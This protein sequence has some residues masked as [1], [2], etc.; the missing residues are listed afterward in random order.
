MRHGMTSS[1]VLTARADTAGRPRA[2]KPQWQNL[3]VE[4]HDLGAVAGLRPQR[5]M[6]DEVGAEDLARL[7]DRYRRR[8]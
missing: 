6:E 4:P 3:F 8:S 7:R 5:A 1:T 2:P